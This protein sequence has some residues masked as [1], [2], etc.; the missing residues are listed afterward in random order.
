MKLSPMQRPKIPP[1]A[2]HRQPIDLLNNLTVQIN[3]ES[4]FETL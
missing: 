3:A 4:Y 1:T 2:D